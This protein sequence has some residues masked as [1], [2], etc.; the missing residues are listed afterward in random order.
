M[1]Y[2][3][4]CLDLCITMLNVS[5][6]KLPLGTL[7]CPEHGPS[8]RPDAHG[9]TAMCHLKYTYKGGL[10]T[11]QMQNLDGDLKEA[12]LATLCGT[13]Q[14]RKATLDRVFTEDAQFW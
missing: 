7:G 1:Y 4:E 11:Y 13:W 6:A 5:L 12:F 10:T 2:V 8:F 9:S 3:A 14:E